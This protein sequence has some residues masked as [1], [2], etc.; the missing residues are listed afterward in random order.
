LR[1]AASAKNNDK[2]TIRGIPVRTSFFHHVRFALAAL[3]YFCLTVSAAAQTS[4][5]IS[6]GVQWLTSQIQA[7]GSLFDEPRSIA[8]ALQSRSEAAYTLK[9]LATVNNRRHARQPYL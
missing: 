1:K 6:R 3:V 2:N 7:D 4:P 9:L 8:T 5:E